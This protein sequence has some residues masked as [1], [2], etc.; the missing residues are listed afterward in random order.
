MGHDRYRRPV[1]DL[2]PIHDRFVRASG[3]ARIAPGRRTP[4]PSGVSEWARS[5][6]ATGFEAALRAQAA[7][8]DLACGGDPQAAHDLACE[9]ASLAAQ[10]PIVEWTAI[11]CRANAVLSGASSIHGPVIDAL[12]ILRSAV[13]SG[14]EIRLA[15][16]LNVAL[17]LL[18]RDDRMDAA[19]LVGIGG[20]LADRRSLRLVP[21][22][23]VARVREEV[24]RAGF[25]LSWIGR[26]TIH[27]LEDLVG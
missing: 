11:V 3:C 5:I 25:D 6:G 24:E 12:D 2:P 13:R 7:H 27:E 19:A 8:I 10:I 4:G 1:H 9:A 18:A 15:S 17:V 23:A 20:E 21:Q 14:N 16:G 22:E 26:R